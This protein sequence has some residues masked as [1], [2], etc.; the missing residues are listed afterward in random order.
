M[1]ILS[2]VLSQ[3]SIHAV[4]TTSFSFCGTIPKELL[5][6]DRNAHD[7][8]II[9]KEDLLTANDQSLE[10]LLNDDIVPTEVT[11][12]SEEVI[13][14]K[15]VVQKKPFNKTTVRKDEGLLRKAKN[16][17]KRIF[18]RLNGE[19]LA[20]SLKKVKTAVIGIFIYRILLL[21]LIRQVR[22]SLRKKDLGLRIL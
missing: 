21:T 16:M 17:D 14:K 9:N 5:S 4:K 2:D 13:E 7:L 19:Q 20:R 6:L 12:T 11:K 1:S 8:C 18:N 10:N 15:K 3:Q 22:R